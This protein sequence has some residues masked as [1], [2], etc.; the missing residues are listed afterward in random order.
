MNIDELNRQ[1]KACRKCRLAETRLNVLC[2]EGSLQG[3]IMLIA[4]APGET[5]DREGRMF[6]GPSGKVLDDLLSAARVDRSSLYI[7]NLVKCILPKY[8]KPKQDE[9]EACSEWLDREIQLV[10][11]DVLVPLGYYAAR[12]V[13]K[14]YALPFSS[15][16]EFGLVA[17]RMVLTEE[18]KILPLSHPAVVLHQPHLKE[19]LTGNYAVLNTL[20]K[21]CRWFPVCP[22]KRYTEQGL[23]DR[24]W[25]QMF[26]RGDWKSC[27]RY[28]MD[29][30]GEPHTDWMLPD[31][32]ISN[33]LKN[34][35]VHQASY[36]PHGYDA[37]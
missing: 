31:G 34:G 25:T 3:R 15:K 20:L 10:N 14:K 5:E 17:G 19:S 16:K 30:K 21:E 37:V 13:F 2:G 7:T 11:P 26:C 24:S 12:H 1:I 32:S 4:Q 6:V 23:L 8:R 29:A 18:I 35:L 36:V 28:Q 27:I 9:I 33:S 22:M